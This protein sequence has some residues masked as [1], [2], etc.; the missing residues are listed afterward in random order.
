MLKI[1]V[2]LFFISLNVFAENLALS[3]SDVS[4]LLPLPTKDEWNLLPTAAATETHAELLP[5]NYVQG[6]PQLIAMAP[7]EQIYDYLHAVGIRI[8]PCF[9]EGRGPVKCQTQIR[10]VWQVLSDQSDDT[11]TFDASLHTFYSVSS[12][13]LQTLV[14]GIKNLKAEYPTPSETEVLG[15]HP[16]IKA[17][18][19]SG[20]YYSRLMA[21]I[22]PLIGAK[23]MTRITFMQLFMTGNIWEFGG[24]DIANGEMKAIMI[25]RINV[26]TQQFINS[27]K[28]QPNWF[29]GGVS[30]APEDK[31][32]FNVL[33]KDSTKMNAGTEAELIAATRAAFKFENPKLSN[34]GTVDCVSCHAAQPVRS[35]ALR[36][37]PGLQLDIR[38][39]DFIYSSP[40]NLTNASPLQTQTNIIRAFG[41]FMD[42]PFV[43][44]RTIN[45]SAEVVNYFNQNYK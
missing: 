25:P 2:I 9:V 7:N 30:P 37:F 14:T 38:N 19:L 16:V 26:A 35:W 31:D 23:N 22:Y 20:A 32:N 18:G 17:Q 41:Y 1:L 5:L 42:S 12:E 45:E 3:L 15:V 34:P 21:L 43:A 4:I 40:Q 6:L 29:R 13:D 44:Q 36:Q 27:A 10:L 28:P 33:V 24:F 39:R 8:D 11:S